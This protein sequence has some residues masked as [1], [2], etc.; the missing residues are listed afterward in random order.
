M[1]YS[2]QIDLIL[3]KL[4]RRKKKFCLHMH[5]VGTK[6]TVKIAFCVEIY[7]RAYELLILILD[8]DLNS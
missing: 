5:Q 3:Y 7:F 6:R 2:V 4:T 8:N 1:I